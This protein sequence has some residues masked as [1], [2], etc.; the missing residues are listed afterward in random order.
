MENK[1]R[2]LGICSSALWISYQRIRRVNKKQTILFIIAFFVL[3][4]G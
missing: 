1:A 3:F 4:Y 2:K